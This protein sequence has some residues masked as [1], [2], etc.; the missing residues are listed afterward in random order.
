MRGYGVVYAVAAVVLVTLPI[1]DLV[2]GNPAL[3]VRVFDVAL[4]VPLGVFVRH[5]SGRGVAATVLIGFLASLGVELTQLV[6]IPWRTFGVDD[7]WSGTLGTLI[8]ALAAP[9]LRPGA[10]P[11]P[12]TGRRRL[13]GMACDAALVI[14]VGQGLL[15]TVSA[16]EY[17]LG[18][19]AFDRAT[20]VRLEP[21][22]AWWLP[23]GVLLILLP[24]LNGGRSPGQRAVL[25]RPVRP[26]GSPPPRWRLLVQVSTGPLLLLLLIESSLVL[27]LLLAHA[28]IAFVP[29]HRGLSGW[30]SGLRFADARSRDGLSRRPRRTG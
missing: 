24:L 28:V 19:G 26:D 20:E 21:I 17:C 6:A 15:V 23:G 29:D 14:V 27:L 3:Q 4:F 13:L 1:P 2:L 8:G 22:L 9:L 16:A 11:R 12:V 30:A 25:L 7:L 10:A 5:V 18:D